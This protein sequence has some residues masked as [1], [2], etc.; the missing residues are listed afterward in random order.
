MKLNSKQYST[1]VDKKEI[2]IKDHVKEDL[3]YK[4]NITA[5]KFYNLDKCK[6]WIDDPNLW[7]TEK[8]SEECLQQIWNDTGCNPRPDKPIKT[9][10]WSDKRSFKQNYT[11][12][13][14]W[15]NRGCGEYGINTT[16]SEQVALNAEDKI[17]KNIDTSS[18][19]LVAV[20][21]VTKQMFE[22][23]KNIKGKIV[24]KI[25]SKNEVMEMFSNG[26]GI[27]QNS[28]EQTKKY[29]NFNLYIMEIVKA[30]N[31]AL[32]AGTHKLTATNILKEDYKKFFE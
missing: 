2:V 1:T 30:Y 10:G 31:K 32:I 23:I 15:R 6:K 27:V 14:F 5:D 28:I 22:N 16:E 12:L 9:T 3:V 13:Q 17:N 26:T 11:D 21:P 18:K 19:K 25:N 29:N 7:K 24:D 4:E 8:I 20:G